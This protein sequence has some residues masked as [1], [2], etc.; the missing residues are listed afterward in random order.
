MQHQDVTK[1]K[2]SSIRKIGRLKHNKLL[3]KIW[4]IVK[5]VCFNTLKNFLLLLKVLFMVVIY[6]M[7][8]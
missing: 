5:I 3:F 6:V 8:C 7:M 1:A 2:Q 4:S